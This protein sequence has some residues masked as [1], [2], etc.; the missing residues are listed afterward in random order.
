M[1]STKSSV[2]QR[3]LPRAGLLSAASTTLCCLG[4]SAA[5]S[6]ATAVGASFLT[7]DAT[8]T[9][10]LTWAATQ[11]WTTTPLPAATTRCTTP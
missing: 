9:R 6:L 5:L 4:I 10:K 11:A 1:M 7:R 8:L 2:A 3:W